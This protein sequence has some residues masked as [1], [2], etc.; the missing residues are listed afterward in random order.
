MIITNCRIIISPHL[1]LLTLSLTQTHVGCQNLSGKACGVA[2]SCTTTPP[3][4]ICPQKQLPA[5]PDKYLLLC[6]HCSVLTALIR[7][8]IW[9]LDF[10][11]AFKGHKEAESPLGGWLMLLSSLNRWVTETSGGPE[12]RS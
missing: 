11:G 3:P 9:Q 7:G 4:Q 1:L 10:N 6:P 2:D 12:R 8:A 5:S